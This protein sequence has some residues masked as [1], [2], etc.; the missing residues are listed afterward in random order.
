[1][2]ILYTD[3][4]QIRGAL[5]IAPED[6]REEV[7][8]GTLLERELKSD[9]DDWLPDHMTLIQDRSTSV[10]EQVSDLIVTYSTYWCANR[11]AAVAQIAVPQ[12]IGDGKNTLKRGND[13]ENV[14]AAVR[15][16]LGATKSK[17]QTLLGGTATVATSQISIVG[18]AIDPVTYSGT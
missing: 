9:L 15:V 5:F 13:F 12:Q 6:L 2:D 18:S 14:V 16:I 4:D 1:M 11:V 10:G 8:N 7:F 17:I 3:T